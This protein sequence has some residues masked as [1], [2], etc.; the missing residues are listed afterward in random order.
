MGRYRKRGK[1][2]NKDTLTTEGMNRERK[3]ME[4]E[5]NVVRLAK[6]ALLCV[7]GHSGKLYTENDLE[8]LIGNIKKLDRERFE[9]GEEPV[10][11]VKPNVPFDMELGKFNIRK[12][13]GS[14]IY[15]FVL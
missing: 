4:Y 5:Q 14:F 6:N 7:T 15:S 12:W 2:H 9:K 11:D 3:K 10:K 13:S 1:D 8:K